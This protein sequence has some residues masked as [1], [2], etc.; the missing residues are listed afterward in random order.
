M[1]FKTKVF[2]PKILAALGDGITLSDYRVRQV[3]YTQGDPA[4]SIFYIQKGKVKL[5]VISNARKEAVIAILETGDFLGEGCLEAQPLRPATSTTMSDCSIIR[6]EKSATVRALHEQ[7][8]FTELFLA[9]L[10]LRNVRI[11]EDLVDQLVNLSE[12]RLARLLLL[13]ANVRKGSKPEP[14]I[15]RIKQEQLATMIGTTRP[16]VNFFMNKFRKRGF[17]DYD[18]R[19]LH[20]HSSLLKRFVLHN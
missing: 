16:R 19:R 18:A 13:L 6:L 5:S 10:L 2:D 15:A 1:T 4:D 9:H 3:I 7:P 11:E 12:K 8:A 17:I 14:F 20:V